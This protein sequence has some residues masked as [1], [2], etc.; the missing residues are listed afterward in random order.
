[1][2]SLLINGIENHPGNHTGKNGAA[3]NGTDN[4]KDGREVCPAL[5]HVAEGKCDGPKQKTN[6]KPES[7]S[8]HI[9][10][11]PR[12]VPQR[13]HVQ[14]SNMMKPFFVSLPSPHPANS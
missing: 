1:M 11:H 5:H 4:G 8:P 7:D 13:R 3:S 9:H 6:Q 14:R 2:F 12:E 10:P